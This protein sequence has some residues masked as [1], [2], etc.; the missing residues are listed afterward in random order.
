MG[1]ARN[2]RDAQNACAGQVGVKLQQKLFPT[3]TEEELVALS[4]DEKSAGVVFGKDSWY[5]DMIVSTR[6][7]IQCTITTVSV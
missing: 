6:L 4:E 2:R 1:P 7:Q 5:L 3:V